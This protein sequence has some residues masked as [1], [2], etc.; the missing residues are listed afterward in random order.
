MFSEEG[1]SKA[2]K[3]TP[4]NSPH[5]VSVGSELEAFRLN[6]VARPDC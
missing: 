2:D 1:L 4:F 5:L 3:S 6:L